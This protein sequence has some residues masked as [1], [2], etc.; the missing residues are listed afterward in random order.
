MAEGGVHFAFGSAVGVVIAAC[1]QQRCGITFEDI[2]L[3]AEA[4]LR[5]R[6]L[7]LLIRVAEILA[8]YEVLHLQGFQVNRAAKLERIVMRE[9]AI[10][11]HGCG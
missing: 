5:K 7:P 2:G 11:I 8:F 3:G 6:Q 10:Y 4:A 9:N 1:P